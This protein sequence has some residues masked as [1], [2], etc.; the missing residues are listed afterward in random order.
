[1]FRINRASLKRERGGEAALAI[2]D[3]PVRVDFPFAVGGQQGTLFWL[4]LKY[5]GSVT[6]GFTFGPVFS[7]G[8]PPRP[9][10]DLTGFVANADS[11]TITVFDKR[12]NQATG[13]IDTC[14]G[15]RGMVLDQPRRRLYVA[16]S[17]DDEIQSID[18][19]RGDV[20]D[21]TRLAPGDRPGE[22]ALTP[23]GQTLLT[24]NTGSNSIAFFSA[25][26]LVRQD[27]V[28]VGSGPRSVVVDPSGRRA[29]VFNTLSSSVS[30]I[31][32]AGRRV[33]ATVSTESPVRGKF[34]ARG[35]RLYVIQDRSPYLTV[36]DPQQLTVVTTARLGGVA[37]AIAVDHVRNLICLGGNRDTAI[38][39][40]DPNA[41]LP[42]YVL[43]T[44]AGAS[45]LAAD[46]VDNNLFVVSPDTKSLLIASLAE[47]RVI[48]E[49][50]VGDGPS[51]VAVAGEK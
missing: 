8:V 44:R 29:F 19:V 32:V 20:V 27:R 36:I 45:Y 46:A 10:A 35:D 39:F 23:D 5:P 43:R 9:I 34:N 42:L 3:A 22:A 38:E 49:I 1:V 13:V 28:D 24:V 31:D 25:S 41:L 16:C 26:S 50:D 6:D 4:S 51:S 11:N 47:R 33:V 2:P 14:A 17:G 15:P 12:L 48:S 7:V 30:V 21:R 37:S 40:Y 18:V